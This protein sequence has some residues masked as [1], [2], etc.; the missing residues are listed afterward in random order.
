M[1]LE[2][3]ELTATMG[4]GGAEPAAIGAEVA[5]ADAGGAVEA[6]T[7]EWVAVVGGVVRCP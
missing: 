4:T 5:G 1:A 3:T 7:G 6:A 2:P